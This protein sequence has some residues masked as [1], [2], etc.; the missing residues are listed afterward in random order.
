M[1]APLLAGPC[2]VACCVAVSVAVRDARGA[3]NAH[4]EMG[5]GNGVCSPRVLGALWWASFLVRCRVQGWPPVRGPAGDRVSR[6]CGRRGRHGVGL[7][8]CWFV[9]FVCGVGL[10]WYAASHGVALAWYSRVGLVLVSCWSRVG[11]VLGCL[12]TLHAYPASAFVCIRCAH[13][14]GDVAS[15]ANARRCTA[16]VRV[17]APPPHAHAGASSVGLQ[18][19]QSA[20]RDGAPLGA[21]V[22]GSGAETLQRA[23]IACTPEGPTPQV[24]AEAS[25]RQVWAEATARVPASL[26][27]EAHGASKVDWMRSNAAT[28]VHWMRCGR[29]ATFGDLAVGPRPVACAAHRQPGQ[30]DICNRRCA[31]E[32]CGRMASYARPDGRLSL[33]LKADA[34][35]PSLAWP[36]SA[37]ATS[38]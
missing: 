24:W 27:L 36:V 16:M 20:D 10:S 8:W 28:Q 30:V 18:S 13:Q 19:L 33:S 38:S 12:G 7:S 6:R 4:A 25:A 9:V 11:L 29:I 22:S 17:I 3:S 15:T 14:E 37:R 35:R 5:E 23:N 26:A 32:T 31:Y 34:Y 1:L 2:S 21:Q